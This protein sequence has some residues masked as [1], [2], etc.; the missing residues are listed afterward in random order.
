MH[1]KQVLERVTTMATVKIYMMLVH[2][3]PDVVRYSIPYDKNGEIYMMSL[4]WRY[5]PI[6]FHIVLIPL[7]T[8]KLVSGDVI[9]A[10]Q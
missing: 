1:K 6:E 9:V 7:D 8:V 4:S 5:I 10:N 3:W 2:S